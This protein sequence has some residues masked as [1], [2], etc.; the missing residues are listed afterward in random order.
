[1]LLLYL[2][3]VALTVVGSVWTAYERTMDAQERS[4]I[5]TGDVS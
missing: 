1:L 2:A 3:G 4:N 5:G